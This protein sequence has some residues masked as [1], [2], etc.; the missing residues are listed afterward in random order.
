MRVTLGILF[1]LALATGLG[2]GVS[3]STAEDTVVIPFGG[4]PANIPH[5]GYVTP[6]PGQLLF[7]FATGHEAGTGAGTTTLSAVRTDGGVACSITVPCT[8][9]DGVQ[10]PADGGVVECDAAVGERELLEFEP[11]EDCATPPTVYLQA[12]F[13]Y[14]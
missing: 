10:V 12:A 14:Q 13:F 3:R 2:V 11:T 4:S 9:A 6:H 8:L 1:G 7:L 5:V